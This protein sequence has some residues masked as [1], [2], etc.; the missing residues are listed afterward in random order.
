MLL[1]CFKHIFL[2]F[3]SVTACKNWSTAVKSKGTPIAAILLYHFESN[4]EW[5][6]YYFFILSVTWILHLYTGSRLGQTHMLLYSSNSSSMTGSWAIFSQKCPHVVVHSNL[7]LLQLHF[8]VT[9]PVEQLQWIIFSSLSGAGVKSIMSGTSLPPCRSQPHSVE[10]MPSL[11]L[12]H[13][14]TCR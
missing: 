6:L 3:F 5:P 10:F 12:I 13:C 2:N 1:W 11:L 14:M 9:H 7:F 4:T 8:W